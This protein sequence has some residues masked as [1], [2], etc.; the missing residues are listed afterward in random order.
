[1]PLDRK[2]VERAAAQHIRLLRESGARPT[3]RDK[4]AIR[5]LHE[6]TAEKVARKAKR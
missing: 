5:R 2:T 6:Q 3:D 4:R 1:M